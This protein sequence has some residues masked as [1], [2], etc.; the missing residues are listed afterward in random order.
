M[1][2]TRKIKKAFFPEAR[3]GTLFFRSTKATPKG[4]LPI[5]DTPLSQYAAEEAIAA[6]IAGIVGKN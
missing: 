5:I 6:D 3:F 1:T 2:N 4:L